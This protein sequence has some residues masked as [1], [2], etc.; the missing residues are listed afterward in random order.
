MSDEELALRLDAL[1]NLCAAEL[2]L[3]RYAD[4]G[5][6]A[7]RGLHIAH[8]TGQA[9]ISP[10]LIPVLGSIL[11]L[12]GELNEAVQ[13]LDGAVE[14]ARLSGNVQAL[15]WNLLNHANAACRSATS[16]RGSAW[17]RR[18]STSRATSITASSHL[19]RGQLA[20]SSTPGQHERRSRAYR[21]RRGETCR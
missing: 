8:A 12:M 21:K 1:A 20:S 9:E 13:V 15:A 7:G 11:Q 16:T 10:F 2:Y 19:R 18:A 4:G 6:H 5:R 17:R 14:A 3:D